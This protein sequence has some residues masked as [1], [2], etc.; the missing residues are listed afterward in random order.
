MLDTAKKRCRL[1][2][3][4]PAY[5]AFNIYSR[6]ARGTTSLGP[7]CVA[8]AANK[9]EK[10]DVE[11]IDENNL[12]RYGPKGNVSGADHE[13]LQSLRPADVVGFYGGL[14]S[15]IPRLYKVARFYKD[16]GVITVAGGQH[17]AEENVPEALNSGVDY[18]VIGEGEE[19][20]GEL[21][22]VFEGR[23][24]LNTVKGIAYRDNNREIVYTAK[25]EPIIDFDKL[26]IP[27]FSLVRYAK[28]KL[29]PVERIR[30]CGMDCE[31][32][33][34]K[35]KPRYSSVERMIERISLILET[36]DARHFFIVDDLFGQQRD[37]TIRFC[38]LLRD[39]QK[40]IRKRLDFSVQI[41][42]DKAN[43]HELLLAMRQAGINT[44]AIGFESPIEEE[45]KAMRKRIRPEDIL[46]LTKTFH[47]FGFLIHGM[48]I[49]G[50]PM[51]E[52]V[53]FSMP[54]KERVK[55]FRNFIKKAKLDTIQV[56]LPGPLAGTELYKRLMRQ[57]RVYP[58]S[59]VGWEYYD[60][61]FPLFEPDKPL[62]AEEMQDSVR[63]I[64]GNFY[65]F[66]HLFRIGLN[67]FSFP[68]LVFFMHDIT[69]GWRIWYRS[70]RN[71]LLRFGGWLT[72][73]EWATKFRKDP[74]LQ[75]L[76]Q[77]KKHIKDTQEKQVNH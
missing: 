3:I 38:N 34:V 26:P 18:I 5:P 65:H 8:S 24:Q 25:R 44:V 27:D 53:S 59:E 49:F 1:R 43:D 15:T 31:F 57:N 71:D 10:W 67:I 9:M 28:I 73:K 11:V 48:F 66:K 13:F 46:K 51:K 55:R 41:R 60:G 33:T 50:Y 47:K 58:T 76:Q 21:L 23:R 62:S 70:W 72:I 36:K 56:L 7:V 14:T 75:K 74:F 39:Y 69:Y 54:A 61:N 30:G 63:K 2:I 68:A 12:R 22:E 19:A 64:M 52:G 20:I 16:R 35:G 4:I 29:Y 17:F 42:L 40:N 37:E 45:L 77:A 6:V 32:C